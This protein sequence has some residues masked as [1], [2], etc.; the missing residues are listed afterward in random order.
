M[1]K[2]IKDLLGL[3]SDKNFMHIIEIVEVI[4]SKLLS[5]LMII[6]IFATLFDLAIFVFKE[7][8][9]SETDHFSQT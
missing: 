3:A 2:L 5:L 4:V 9:S 1:R 6:V 7:I 8:F